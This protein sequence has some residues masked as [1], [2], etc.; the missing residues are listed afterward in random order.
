MIKVSKIHHRGE[1]RLKLEFPF[2]AAFA[3]QIKKIKGYA[4]SQSHKAW[5]VPYNNETILEL[6]ERFSDINLPFSEINTPDSVEK[7][8]PI[9][10]TGDL[11]FHSAGNRVN[12]KIIRI[13]VIGRKIILSLGTANVLLGNS[14]LS[15]KSGAVE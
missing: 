8:T 9:A 12:R 15:R 1:D 11:K 10:E 3:N 13:E 2:N 7:E 4:W 5:L 14:Q 6:R